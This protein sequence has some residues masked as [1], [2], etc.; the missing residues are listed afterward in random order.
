MKKGA[1]YLLPSLIG[2]VGYDRCLPDYNKQ[3]VDTLSNFIV[4]EERSAY[5]ILRSIGFTRDFSEVSFFVLNEHTKLEE[6]YTYL[7]KADKGIDLGLLSE[8][9]LPCIADPGASIVKLAH[10]K[11][12][13]VIPLVGPNSIISALISSGLNGQNFAFNGYLPVKSPIRE[14][15]IKK[16]EHLS[17]E[18]AQTQIFIEAPYRNIQMFESLLKTCDPETFLCVASNIFCEDQ[19]I[20]TKTIRLWKTCRPPEIHKKPSVFLLLKPF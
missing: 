16:I 1:L 2:P 19:F 6:T 17:K 20:E 11:N 8:T 4:E 15:T 13:R 9:G 12:I 10:E 18:Y 14:Q 7:D 3:I 5:K